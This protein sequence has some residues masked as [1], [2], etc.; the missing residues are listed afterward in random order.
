M[1]CRVTGLLGGCAT[2]A[3]GAGGGGGGSGLRR[4]APAGR[5]RLRAAAD[6]TN[7]TGGA[8]L[9]TAVQGWAAGWAGST[10]AGGG[11]GTGTMREQPA[12]PLLTAATRPTVLARS[13]CGSMAGSSSSARAPTAAA[14]A[15]SAASARARLAARL[16]AEHWSSPSPLLTVPPHPLRLWLWLAPSSPASS[17]RRLP[18]LSASPAGSAEGSAQ[19]SDSLSGARW[20]AS[21]SGTLRGQGVCAAEGTVLSSWSRT[22]GRPPSARSAQPTQP[23]HHA[24]KTGHHSRRAPAQ[25][26]D[27]HARLKQL[28]G[29]VGQQARHQRRGVAA[30]KVGGL[31]A[32]PRAPAGPGEG[33]AAGQVGARTGHACCLPPGSVHCDFTTNGLLHT[34]PTANGK[35]IC[36]A[37]WRAPAAAAPGAWRRHVA[38]AHTLRVLNRQLQGR[39][40]L[41]RCRGRHNQRQ[42][43]CKVGV[44]GELVLGE[45]R[46]TARMQG[47]ARPPCRAM[48]LHMPPMPA[49]S[50][51]CRPAPCPHL[52]TAPPRSPARWCPVATRSKRSRGRCAAA[53]CRARRPS[54]RPPRRRRTRSPPCTPLPLLLLPGCAAQPLRTLPLPRRGAERPGSQRRAQR[55]GWAAPPPEAARWA[56]RGRTC[57][58]GTW[59]RG[60][61]VRDRHASQVGRRGS[62]APQQAGWAAA[63]VKGWRRRRERRQQAA[64]P[65]RSSSS[66][67]SSSST[68]P[69]QSK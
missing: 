53:G 31:Q 4:G 57:E 18:L 52:A 42:R 41:R 62:D 22:H 7:G 12:A 20:A 33:A 34:G 45:L 63:E 37:A 29:G 35:C 17:A 15:A 6:P 48:P 5:P 47:R 51:R 55:R 13:S 64:H 65:A 66:F 61:G 2:G 67:A 10:G 11:S 3:G 69:R 9:G 59:E 46:G 19:P 14:T 60:C 32:A 23:C 56:T 68:S 49:A 24:P 36:A 21:S 50:C 1:R 44:G 16:P 43:R 38:Q 25:L 27:V 8:N 54:R 28:L 30:A 26:L 58:R 40:P 39:A